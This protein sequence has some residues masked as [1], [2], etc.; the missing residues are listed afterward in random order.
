MPEAFHETSLK[1]LDQAEQRGLRLAIACRTAVIGAALLWYVGASFVSDSE[2]RLWGTFALLLFTLIGVAH[3]LA[4]GT[5]FDRWWL[6]YAIYTVDILGICVLFAIIP[7]SRGD[8]VPQIIAFRAYGIYYL[9]PIVVMA[10][11]SL[12][13]RLVLWSGLVAVVGWWAAFFEIVSTMDRTLSWSDLPAEATRTDYETIFLS[14]DFIGRGNRLEETGFLLAGALILS[15]AVYRARNVFFAQVAAEAA[16]EDERRAREKIRD[17]LGRYVPEA[18]ARKLVDDPQALEPQLRHGTVLML[19]IADFTRYA[20]GRDPVEVIR[21][22]GG[23]LASAADT[24]GDHEGIVISFTGDGLLASFNAPVELHHPEETAVRAALAL[25]DLS[26][27]SG[28]A[29]RVGIA[30]GNIAAGRIGSERR[31]AFTIYGDIVN[32]ASRLEG[33]GKTLQTPIVIDAAT[34][35]RIGAQFEARPQGTRT[36]RGFDDP[37]EIFT[38]EP[39]AELSATA[40]AR[41]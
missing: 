32:L 9:F 4:I 33:L 16:R 5:R 15:L 37:V 7:I 31:Q 2:P 35:A 26:R 1:R 8:D 20:A 23:F 21:A 3:L 34:Q 28:F 11:L 19:D 36:I 6:K 22:L 30:S 25:L 13:W 14:I 38:I 29:I 18:I 17:T 39:A 40:S 24:I 12:S 27:R 41:G 10:G